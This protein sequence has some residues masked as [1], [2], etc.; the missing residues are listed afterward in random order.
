MYAGVFNNPPRPDVIVRPPH[1]LA[2]VI[3]SPRQVL[4]ASVLLCVRIARQMA[5]DM[6][7]MCFMSTASDSDYPCMHYVSV[8]LTSNVI[9]RTYYVCTV[10]RVR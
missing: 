9:V 2:N 7:C 3:M 6:H 4:I 8:S 10:I 5:N 1:V